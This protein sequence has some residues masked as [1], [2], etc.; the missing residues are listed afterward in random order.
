MSAFCEAIKTANRKSWTT[1]QASAVKSVRKLAY[2]KKRVK[3][4]NHFLKTPF[5]RWLFTANQFNFTKGVKRNGIPLTER[6]HCDGSP[7]IL[8]LGL[9]IGGRRDLICEQV[10]TAPNLL[11]KNGPGSVYLGQLTVPGIRC[12]IA[13]AP[14]MN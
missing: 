10:G 3:N 11:V 7:S 8:H 12:S 13:R 9:G 5:D 14:M 2:Q 1:M 4:A 6:K